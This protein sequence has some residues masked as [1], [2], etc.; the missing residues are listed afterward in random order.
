MAD[1][2]T[3]QNGGTLRA[4]AEEAGLVYVDDSRPGLTRKRSGT[5][6]RY[7][8]AKGAPVRD[9]RVLAR[10]R[11]L[12]IP[13]AYTDVWICARSS[14]HIQATGRDAKGRK[15][16]RYHPDFRQAREANKFSRIMAF[17]D[18]LPGI[19][20]R[21]DADMKR[22]GLCREK[23]LATVVHLLETTLIRVGND[24]YARTNKSYGLTTLRDP[25]VRIEG[26]E[27]SFRFKGKSGKT[28]DVSLKDRRVARIV[29]A[30]QDL[31]GQELFQ[32]IDGDGIQR[33]VTSSDVNA[34][35][36]EVTGE[37]FTAKD[38][39]TWAGTVLAAL[40]LREF[41]SFDSEAGAKRNV[42]AAIESVAG[43]L[44]NTPTICRKCYIHPQILDCY[45]EGD[46]LLQ[47]KDAVETELSGDLGKL[48]SEE[49]A[50]LGLLQARLAASQ[51]D[52]KAGKLVKPAAAQVRKRGTAKKSASRAKSAV[53]SAAK[54]SANSAA[55]GKRSSGGSRG[56]A[57]A[58]VGVV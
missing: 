11:A 33:D 41:E 34:Y 15:Q 52:A 47:V 45:L 37:D 14:G 51:D 36:R 31:P 43:R 8:D 4:A 49:A 24:D 29:K 58:Q 35:L 23:V 46:L 48:R 54:S 19:R 13:P 22:P 25:H 38:F 9:T 16:Y 57:G 7:L 20:Q 32:Y 6:F 27:L 1:V 56:R 10:I 40:A 53:K 55:S 50:V 30:C 3:D 21:V 17:A 44:G 18:A 12:A 26:A 28:W 5:G 39:R 42:R 2:E